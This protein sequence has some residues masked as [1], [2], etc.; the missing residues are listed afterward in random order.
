M[1]ACTGSDLR[2]GSYRI[3][4]SWNIRKRCPINQASAQQSPEAH[5]SYI[6]RIWRHSLFRYVLVGG[7]AFLLDAGTLWCMHSVLG[8]GLA[9]STAIAFW[10][11]FIF[12]YLA[13]RAFSFRSNVPH[14]KGLIFYILL[15][16]FNMFA[17]M[18]IVALTAG[19]SMHWITGKTA[20]TV[21]VAC[22]N[23]FA[24]RWLV[25]P[26][27]SQDSYLSGTEK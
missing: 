8:A 20:A 1:S 11:G 19:N 13:Q 6:V 23:Y 24:Y 14:G 22:W 17:T 4:I 18:G 21:L 12:S 27:S 16:V 5:P 25:F 3:M 26:A 2:T 9:I 7:S 10:V 15:L